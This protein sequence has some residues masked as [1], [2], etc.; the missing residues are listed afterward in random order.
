MSIQ[1]NHKAKHPLG[2]CGSSA[3]SSHSWRKSGPD[4]GASEKRYAWPQYG[5]RFT[6]LLWDPMQ[7]GPVNVARLAS[8]TG[9]GGGT[10]KPNPKP[11]GDKGTVKGGGK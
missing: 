4:H 10:S 6:S 1:R 11:D 7:Q 3:G 9:T 2:R 5:N 8:P